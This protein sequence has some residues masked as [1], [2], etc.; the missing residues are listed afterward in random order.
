MG[1]KIAKQSIALKWK[2]FSVNLDMVRAHI[3]SLEPLCCGLAGYPDRFEVIFEEMVSE[4]SIDAIKT[5]WDSIDNESEEA[6][7]YASQDAVNAAIIAAKE[8]AVTKSW[9]QLSPAQRKMMMGLALTAEDKQ[10][11][12]G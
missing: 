4:E 12:L 11:L 7:T 2:E 6:T 1:I 8:D 5:Y 10:S 9:D 3:V